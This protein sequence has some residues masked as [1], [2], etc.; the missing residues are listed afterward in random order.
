MGAWAE[1]SFGN[2]TSCDWIGDFLE[3]PEF[4]SVQE[5]IDAVLE[6]EDFLDSD[7]ACACIAA[8]EVIARLQGKWGLKNAYSEDLDAWVLAHPTPVP[9]KLKDAAEKA[10]AKILGPESELAELWDED[11]PNKNWH[12]AMDDLRQRIRG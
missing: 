2:D 12:S 1:D 8:C 9:K 11:G 10:I 4:D 5:A 3:E 6:A 7:E